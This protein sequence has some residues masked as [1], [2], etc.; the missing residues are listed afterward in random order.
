M[1]ISENTD[2][3]TY[4]YISK[5]IM[6]IPRLVRIIAYKCITLHALEHYLGA[7]QLFEPVEATG[8]RNNEELGKST[9]SIR[10]PPMTQKENESDLM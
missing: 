1:Y 10:C 7:N 9:F 6:V 8:S 3:T 2:A 4:Y 5:V